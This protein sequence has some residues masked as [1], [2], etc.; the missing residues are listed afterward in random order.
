MRATAFEGLEAN[1]HFIALGRLLWYTNLEENSSA[2]DFEKKKRDT[3]ALCKV[4]LRKNTKGNLKSARHLYAER[5]TDLPSQRL[6]G[7]EL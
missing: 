6:Q 7:H 1:V 3:R 5:F 2:F 4:R